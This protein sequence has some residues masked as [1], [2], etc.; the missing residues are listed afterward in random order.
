MAKWFTSLYLL[1]ILVGS[2]S[3][4]TPF[5]DGGMKENN[6]CPMKCCKKSAKAVKPQDAGAKF[7]C[8]TLIC[9]QNLPTNTA[10]NAPINFAP[11]LIVSEKATLFEILFSTR[12]KEAAK[13][14][15]IKNFRLK[16]NQ[17]KYIQH[18]S[19]LI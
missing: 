3:A 6:V 13:K 15:D 17:P 9:S 12:P 18:Q 16:T 14:F 19:F 4:G 11:M 2:V 8:R 10:N 5:S 7:L 1:I